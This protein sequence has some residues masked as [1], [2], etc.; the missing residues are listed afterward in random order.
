LLSEDIDNL[1]RDGFTY[2]EIEEML[3]TDFV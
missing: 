3:Y 1:L 2:D